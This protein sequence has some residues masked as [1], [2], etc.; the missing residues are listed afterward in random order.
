M[1]NEWNGKLIAFLTPD[2]VIL[3]GFLLGPKNSNTCI[4]Y[5][6]GMGSNFHDSPLP[7][8]IAKKVAKQNISVFAINTRGHDSVSFPD[9]KIGRHTKSFLAGTDFEKF[10][11]C[12]HDISG[13]IN[14]LK[15]IKF[16][17]F[18]LAGHSTGC[19]KVTYYQYKKKDRNVK[20]II[21]LA[22]GD[23]YNISRRAHKRKFNGLVSKCRALVRRKMGSKVVPQNH[24]S[25]RR[26]LSIADLKYV[27]ARLC[28]YDGAL[29][30][31]GKIQ[32][33]ICA[34]FGSREQYAIKPVREYLEIL[35]KKSHAPIYVSK[36]IKGA[37][38]SFNGQEDEVATSISS[39]LADVSQR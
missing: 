34:V 14:S 33:P 19:Q 39:W 11:D 29:S 31:F 13:A 8:S 36:I 15:K 17:K 37:R 27:E 6:H 21:L 12:V 1:E 26:F 20:G 5:V 18:I 3:H 30:E 2:K 32:V 24:F 35:K 10:E 4:I 7:F 16:N 25:A 22:P 9:K 28:N 23:D 38:H